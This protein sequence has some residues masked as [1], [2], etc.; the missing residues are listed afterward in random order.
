M[1]FFSFMIIMTLAWESDNFTCRYQNLTDSTAALNREVNRRMNEV[2]NV[3]VATHRKPNHIEI[4]R[5]IQNTGY[6]QLS[7]QDCSIAEPEIRALMAAENITDFTEATQ[8][9]SSSPGV[10][11]PLMGCDRT[12]LLSAMRGAIASPFL[13]TIGSWADGS[14]EVSRCLPDGI[15]VY[16]N[17]SPVYSRL[18][19]ITGLSPVVQVNNVRIGTDKIEHFMTEGYEYYE[20]QLEGGSLEEILA[21]GT[22]EEENHYGLQPAGIKSYGDMAANYSGYLFW[23]NLTD[24]DNP[25]FRCVGNRWQQQKQFNWSDYVNPSWDESINCSEYRNDN[26]RSRVDENVRALQ[27][28]TNVTVA[29][30][31]VVMRDC[32][33]MVNH[34]PNEFVRARVIH[35]S[36]QHTMMA[37]EEEGVSNETRL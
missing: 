19:G 14:S 8:R 6:D 10:P 23:K 21:I 35:P 22:F 20:K 37:T 26:M 24:G 34:I 7:E 9:W 12:E 11:Q 17:F 29:T 2:V 3:G 4:Q 28:R 16:S 30:C 32:E 15:G 27:R 25:Y 5:R 1:I 13:G 36:C 31:P 33:N 18:L